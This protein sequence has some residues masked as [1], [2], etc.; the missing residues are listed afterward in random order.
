MEKLSRVIL[1]IQTSFAQTRDQERVLV[2]P[3]WVAIFFPLISVLNALQD[4]FVLHMAGHDK[5]G[6]TVFGVH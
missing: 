4:C 5:T 2:A 1:D 6:C 3:C